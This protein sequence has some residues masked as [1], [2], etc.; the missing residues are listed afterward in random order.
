MRRAGDLRLAVDSMGI[1]V[2]AILRTETGQGCFDNLVKRNGLLLSTEVSP[3]RRN[4]GYRR[5]GETSAKQIAATA[6]YSIVNQSQAHNQY[7]SLKYAS[8]PYGFSNLR[9]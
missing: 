3:E 4:K 7:R 5:S 9:K 8:P 1:S 6:Q 2:S